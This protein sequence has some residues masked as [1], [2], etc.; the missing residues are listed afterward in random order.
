MSPPPL[1]GFDLLTDATGPQIDAARNRIVR[2]GLST[3]AGTTVYDGDEAEVIQ[4]VDH[5]LAV[6]APGVIV[7]WQGS[8]LDLPLFSMRSRAVGVVPGLRLRADHRAAPPS[9]VKDVDHPWCAQWHHHAHLELRRVYDN[10]ARWWNPLRNR[11]DPESMIPPA[12]ALARRDPGRDADLA[13]C[14]AERRWARA[15]KSIDRMP[16]QR[17]RGSDQTFAADTGS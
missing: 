5:R 15:R 3:P 7:T 8:L 9:V 16:D 13:R 4:L 12:N 2:V 17:E 11:L 14:L 10:E 1:Y 6:L